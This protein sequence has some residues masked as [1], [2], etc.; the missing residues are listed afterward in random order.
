MRETA[1]QAGM[2]VNSVRPDLSA[3]SAS[4]AVSVTISL[5]GG[6]DNFRTVL[7][8]IGSLPFLENIESVSVQAMPESRML[9]F[10]LKVLITAS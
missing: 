7:M 9:N 1:I 4:G 8:N 6:F 3:P 2:S 10:N 5:A